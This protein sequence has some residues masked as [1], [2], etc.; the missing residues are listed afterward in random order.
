LDQVVVAVGEYYYSN[1]TKLIEKRSN[2][3]K[4]GETDIIQGYSKRSIEWKAGPDPKYNSIQNYASL[5]AFVVE[6]V[7]YVYELVS[8]LDTLQVKVVELEE[9]LRTQKENI[10]E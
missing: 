1:K 2:K 3:R 7:M 6:I 9:E 5:N 4:R 8:T 10:I